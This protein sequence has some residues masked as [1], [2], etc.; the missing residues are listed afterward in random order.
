MAQHATDGMSPGRY[1]N[2]GFTP[3]AELGRKSTFATILANH[4]YAAVVAAV[5]F[6][7][8]ITFGLVATALVLTSL[9]A[10]IAYN[11]GKQS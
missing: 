3:A 2:K 4:A 5:C 6:S 8:S 9:T 10:T 1:N 11:L 7:G